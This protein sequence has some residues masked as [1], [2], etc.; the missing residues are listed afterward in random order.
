MI[1][2]TRLWKVKGADLF[3][4][5]S[6]ADEGLSLG[7]VAIVSF[8]LGDF[9]EFGTKNFEA[10]RLVLGLGASVLTLDLKAGGQ[11]SNLHCGVCR[12][13]VLSAGAAGTGGLDVKIFGPELDID[14][15]GFRQ[16]RDR[17]GG[18][19]DAALGFLSRKSLFEARSK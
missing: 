9:E 7:G 1:G 2:Y 18:G 14:F 8:A 19:V 13:D 10:Q 5:I 11:V 6:R 4:A 15:L 12:V 3:G 16:Y 17:H